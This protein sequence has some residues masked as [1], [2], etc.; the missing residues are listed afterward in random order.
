MK[1]KY[2][3]IYCLLLTAHCQLHLQAQTWHA[4]GNG[5]GF[6]TS[7]SYEV[8]SLEVINDALYVGG[9]FAT[10]NGGTNVPG[11]GIAVFNGSNWD[12][13]S[14]GVGGGV[15]DI[16]TFTDGKLYISGGFLDVC[17]DYSYRFIVIWNGT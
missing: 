17:E 13:L 9:N 10:E 14:C 11:R 3:Y 5:V 2:I 16:D 1:I 15:E 7:L 12:S 8:L 4:V 6:S